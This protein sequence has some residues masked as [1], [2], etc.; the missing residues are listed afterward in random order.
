MK[1]SKSNSSAFGKGL[2][3]LGVVFGIVVITLFFTPFISNVG[4]IDGFKLAFGYESSTSIGGI[5][6]ITTET[7]KLVPLFLIAF[8]LACVSVAVGLISCFMKDKI[9]AVT[10][11]IGAL[12]LIVAGVF[13]FVGKFNYA[14]VNNID[15]ADNVKML[16]GAIL[17]G[18]YSFAGALSY[19]G[20]AILK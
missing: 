5:V 3:L 10:L 20:A 15:N 13:F 14:S 18:S 4:S 7:V 19:V 2:L 8:I 9:K 6:S 17:A 12:V 1:K 16:A 11:L